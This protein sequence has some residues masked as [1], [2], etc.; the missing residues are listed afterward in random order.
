[1]IKDAIPYVIYVHDA[2]N[3]S[4]P[5]LNHHSPMLKDR[6][7]TPSA[8]WAK[9]EYFS[10][11]YASNISPSVYITLSPKAYTEGSIGVDISEGDQIE[12][13]QW[14]AEVVHSHGMLVGM[15]NSVELVPIMHQYFDFALN[16]EC[17]QWDEC[18][19][20]ESTF[21]ADGKPVFNVEY[22]NNMDQCD[23]AIAMNIDSIVKVRLLL[24]CRHACRDRNCNF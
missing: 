23:Q 4:F 20:Y 7:Y 14:F 1:M 2:I 22:K 10:L 19:V 13:N 18:E 12:Y 9:R 24:N 16:E 5:E 15:K 11:V 21:L 6:K 17:F 8:K 3:P